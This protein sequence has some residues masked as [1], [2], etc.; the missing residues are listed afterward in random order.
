M[1]HCALLKWKLEWESNQ[2]YHIVIVRIICILY[3][4]SCGINQIPISRSGVFSSV[5]ALYIP[6]TE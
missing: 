6:F 2:Y 5:H 3:R 1:L 4:Y